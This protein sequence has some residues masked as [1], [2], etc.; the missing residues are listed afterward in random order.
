[1]YRKNFGKFLVA[2][3]SFLLCLQPSVLAA[4]DLGERVRMRARVL[5]EETRLTRS[6]QAAAAVRLDELIREALENN[7]AV[8]SALRRVEARRR[9]VPQ[10]KS[11]PDPVVSVGW[12]GDIKPF[13]V[14]RNDPSSFRSLSARQQIP[15]PGKLKLRGKIADR[16]AEAAWW[17]YE[18]IRRR[19]V[20]QVKV[21]YYDYF[22]YDKA[23]QITL[24]NKELLEKLTRIAEVRYQVGKGIQQDVLRAQVELSRLLQRLTILEQQAKTAQVRLN[25]LLYREP[26]AP[27]PA[28]APFEPAE[29]HYTLDALYQLAR[30]NDT[31]LQREQRLIERNQL[32]V[33]LAR[34]EYY[35]DFGIGYMYQNRPLIPEMH[36]FTF[37]LNIPVFYRSK[38]REGVN[39]ATEELISARRSRENRETTLYFE[40]KEQYLAAK[41]S[42]ELARLFSRAIVPQSSLALESSMAAY[43]V[44]KV[45]FLTMLDNF[46]TVLDYEVNYYR[47]LTNFQQALARLE[48]LV[49]MELT[50]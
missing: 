40:V 2:A 38:Q 44:G 17:E 49:G 43:E 45:D 29:L 18:N 47:E 37:S 21:A 5:N 19:V 20:S 32:A 3:S 41:A 14:M 24:K 28:P 12:M 34:K 10:V 11:L 26:E 31:G 16:E 27:L 48:P 15:F 36:G 33:N 50:K 42:E 4:Q 8:K 6:E 1:M 9:R 22:Y 30:E 25:T 23:I 46:M 35:P 13:G 39:E 7:P